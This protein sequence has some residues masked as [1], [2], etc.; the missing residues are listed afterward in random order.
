MGIVVRLRRRARRRVLEVE[1]L[2]VVEH[3]EPADA[4]LDVLAEGRLVGCPGLALLVPQVVEHLALVGVGD[5]RVGGADVPDP[6]GDGDQF[7]EFDLIGARELPQHVHDAAVWVEVRQGDDG[8][9]VLAVEPRGLGLD[10]LLGAAGL[11]PPTDD[12]RAGERVVGPA[13]V[14]ALL[15]RLD[16]LLTRA[17]EDLDGGDLLADALQDL[18]RVV[19]VDDGVLAGLW[20]QPY[21]DGVDRLLVK[22][23]DGV[24]D[25]LLVEAGSALLAANLERLRVGG[26]HVDRHGGDVARRRLR[27][28]SRGALGLRSGR[29]LGRR[30][31]CLRRGGG[32]MRLYRLGRGG[33]HHRLLRRAAGRCLPRVVLGL[34][35]R[36]EDPGI[37]HPLARVEIHERSREPATAR[38][39]HLDRHAID[40]VFESRNRRVHDLRLGPVRPFG[41]HLR[42]TPQNGLCRAL[43]RGRLLLRGDRLRPRRRRRRR[44]S[45]LLRLDVLLEVVWKRRMVRLDGGGGRILVGRGG[46]RSGSGRRRGCA[47]RLVRARRRPRHRGAGHGHPAAHKEARGPGHGQ[48]PEI[49][50]LAERGRRYGLL[51]DLLR[52]L[53][54]PGEPGVHG[55]HLGD[56]LRALGGEQLLAEFPAGERPEQALVQQEVHR[57]VDAEHPQGLVVR[58]GCGH[59]VLRDEFSLDVA[60]FGRGLDDRGGGFGTLR[61]AEE[62]HHGRRSGD[63]SHRADGRVEVVAVLLVGRRV[64][65]HPV[66]RPLGDLA[67][68]SVGR[69]GIG[70][71]WER[72]KGR[73]NGRRGVHP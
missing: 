57:Q 34:L 65:G 41:R 35:Q 17:L 43:G 71:L 4:A 12:R 7:V 49:L 30:R 44:S 37:F 46:G 16:R 61:A 24:L 69:G 3:P 70:V 22:V 28:Q 56:G 20:V 2:R 73:L 59:S 50:L 64:A 58:V 29:R 67:G 27:R 62:R 5:L 51:G 11:A 39:V 68:R 8:V 6:L 53:L 60:L 72:R 66:V 47:G 9:G 21:L 1:R 26:D 25:E 15:G 19:P 45:G 63:G 42:R 54:Q 52:A 32:G 13:R 33:G 40:F 23:I 14:V 38:V 55:D 31:F 48:L 10:I 18:E 36:R